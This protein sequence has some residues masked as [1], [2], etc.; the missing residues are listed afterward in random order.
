M[1]EMVTAL[2]AEGRFEFIGGGWSMHDEATVHYSSLIDNMSMG[3]K[4]LL[5]TFGQCA[6][7]HV[8]WQIDPFGHSK[9]NAR[10]FALMGFDGLFFARADYREKLLDIGQSA[11]Y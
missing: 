7:P 3:F 6:V 9:E 5:D 4:M 2:V 11:K 10:L 1:K 8:A